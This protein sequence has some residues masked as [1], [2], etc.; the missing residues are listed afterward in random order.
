MK[1]KSFLSIIVLFIFVLCLNSFAQPE[2]GG[3]NPQERMK[4]Q[5]EE[6]KAK[7]K[8]TNTQFKKIENILKEQSS[9]MQKMRDGKAE[10]DR[11]AMR[12]KFVKM[13]EATN[14]KIEKVLN[15]N[16]IVDFRKIQEEQKQRMQQMMQNRGGGGG[17]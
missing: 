12:E 11:E 10:G 16:Q 2:P 7:L 14:K 3:M 15:K 17:M 8:L 5:L 1:T 13:R 9:E 4:K 6:Y